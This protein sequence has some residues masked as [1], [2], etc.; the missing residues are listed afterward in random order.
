LS[1]C[2]IERQKHR[3]VSVTEGSFTPQ[4]WT[5]LNWTEQQYAIS[6]VTKVGL[7]VWRTK[8]P[9]CALV[10][11]AKQNEYVGRIYRSWRWWSVL[12][13]GWKKTRFQKNFFRFLKFLGFKGFLG[14]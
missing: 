10:A 9:S 7:Q 8:R 11:A 3:L 14:F 13:Q 4:N 12:R 6:P 2:L 5:Q 1:V